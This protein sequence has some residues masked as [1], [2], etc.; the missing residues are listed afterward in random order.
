[1]DRAVSEAM[2]WQEPHD[3][4]V[5][6]ADP[7]VVAALRPIAAAVAAAP[8]AQWWSTPLDVARLR[9]TS[10]YDEDHPPTPPVLS[11]AAERL[12][13]WRAE[14]LASE[15]TA[16]LERPADPAARY[17]A[18]WWSTPVMASLVTTTRALPGLGSIQL[19]WEEDS[20][21]QRSAQVWPLRATR[22]PRAWEINRP[23]EWVS[24][25]E[26]YP[27]EVTHARRYDWYRTTGR[28]GTWHIPDVRGHE[29]V[30]TGGRVAVPTGG[31]LKV[32][33]PRVSCPGLRSPA[34]CWIRHHL[35]DRTDNA[36]D[37]AAGRKERGH[38]YDD[39]E[40]LVAKKVKDT[41]ARISLKRL[42][43]EA[44][45]AGYEGSARNF[46][47]LVAAQ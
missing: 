30:P 35:L 21:G 5:L 1:M 11:G 7:A 47:R 29:K 12:R 24:L 39:V 4:D 22:A 6:G 37:A 10:R 14:M 2:Y 36:A 46:R 8:A 32:P 40:D 43:P 3:V 28:V 31:Q 42:L 16:A 33:T 9:Y 34:R 20:F 23:Q 45:A 17:S 27:L 13:R 15:R 26:R 41:K 38:N 18:A 44:R 25:V 19:A